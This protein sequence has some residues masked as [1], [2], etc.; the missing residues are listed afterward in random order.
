M[1]HAGG[2][3]YS[4]SNTGATADESLTGYIDIATRALWYTNGPT[5]VCTSQPQY[6]YATTTVSVP[7]NGMSYNQENSAYLFAI[8]ADGKSC[9]FGITNFAPNTAGSIEASL[10]EYRD[11]DVTPTATGYI[12]TADEAQSNYS[13]HYTITDLNINLSSQCQVING[14]FKCKDLEF[15]IT[16]KM[17]PIANFAQPY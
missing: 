1:T 7:S 12:I 6:P 5:M 9:T 13:G 10:I 14:S 15:S 16:G 3:V 17:F 8:N 4:F 2:T 11:I